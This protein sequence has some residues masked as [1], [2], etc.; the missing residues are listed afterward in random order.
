VGVSGLVLEGAGLLGRLLAVAVEALSP[1][2]AP[3]VYR[4]ARGSTT[5]APTITLITTTIAAVTART[6]MAI[7]LGPTGYA[8][9]LHARLKPRD[10]H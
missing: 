1:G 7:R 6:T 9:L 8:H 5:M 3:M 2:C 10:S 4:F